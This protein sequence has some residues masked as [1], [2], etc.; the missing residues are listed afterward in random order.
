MFRD[1]QSIAALKNKREKKVRSTTRSS[2]VQRMK[3][4]KPVFF[5]SV[6]A[7]YHEIVCLFGTVDVQA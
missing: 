7:I 5:Q 6:T 1:K 4:G 2:L 3:S